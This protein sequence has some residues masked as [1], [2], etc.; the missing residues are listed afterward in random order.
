MTDDADRWDRRYREQSPPEGPVEIVRRFADDLPRGR[1]LDVACG[2]GRNAIFLAERGFDVA[3]VDI[4][5][6]ALAHA[7]RRAADAGVDVDFARAD[8]DSMDIEEGAYDVVVVSH[9]RTRE[10]LPDLAD[11]LAPGGVLLYEHRLATGGDHRFRVRP[12]ELL[13]ACLGLRIV[14][15]EEPLDVTSD[16]CTVRLAARRRR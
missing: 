5:E 11:A 14:H 15:Y 1:V 9:F 4:S 13:R 7:R 3:A 8:V 16:D 2:G 10:R 12:N 6:E